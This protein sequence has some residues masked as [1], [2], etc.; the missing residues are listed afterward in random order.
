M[1]LFSQNML[2]LAVDLAVHDRTYESMVFKFMK[3][4]PKQFS[5]ED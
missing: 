2:K 5:H 4:S 3:F 1:A